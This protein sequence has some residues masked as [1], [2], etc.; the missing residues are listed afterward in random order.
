MLDAIFVRLRFMPASQFHEWL[1]LTG[2]SAVEAVDPGHPPKVGF[3]LELSAHIAV[4]TFASRH[5]PTSLAERI[6]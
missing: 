5:H 3:H 6:T 2:V 4:V 1:I